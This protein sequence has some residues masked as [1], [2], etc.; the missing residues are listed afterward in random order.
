LARAGLLLLCLLLV[1]CAAAA[2]KT[3]R[4]TYVPLLNRNVPEGS[5]INRD[6]AS[7]VLTPADLRQAAGVAA[8]QDLSQSGPIDVTGIAPECV[9]GSSARTNLRALDLSGAYRTL[10][11]SDAAIGIARAT[12]AV[13]TFRSAGGAQGALNLTAGCLGPGWIPIG[14][15]PVGDE[16]RAWRSATTSG[17]YLLLFRTASVLHRI[18]AAAASGETLDPTMRLARIAVERTIP[19]TATPTPSASPTITA[20]TSPVP[21]ATATDTPTVTPTATFTVTPTATPT[22]PPGLEVAAGR[23]TDASDA[24]IG[25]PASDAVDPQSGGP[26]GQSG[27]TYWQAAGQASPLIES[28]W[29]TWTV[30]LGAAQNVSAI[31]ARLALAAPGTVTVQLRLLGTTGNQ[32]LS[33]TLFSGT[34]VDSQVVAMVF[35]TPVPATRQIYLIFTESPS[36]VAP[37][38]R[39]VGVYAQ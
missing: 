6:A 29:R 2:A 19:P 35:P 10:L 25:H 13:G 1:G 32:V 4:R 23:V 39:T 33:Q 36:G 17:S 38:L 21:S 30:N 34:A 9:E 8:Y 27:L 14:V 16:S 18:E 7:L 20:T 12:H 15:E 3:T 24:A 5:V 22:P 26:N 31:Q 28:S 11:R 37:G